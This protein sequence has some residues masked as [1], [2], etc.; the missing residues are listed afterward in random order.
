MG[1]RRHTPEQTIDKLKQ[2]EVEIANGATVAQVCKVIG[3]TDRNHCRPRWKCAGRLRVLMEQTIEGA[4]WLEEGRMKSA[5]LLGALMLLSL[6]MPTPASEPDPGTMEPMPSPSGS[7]GNTV[8]FKSTA[9]TGDLSEWVGDGGG[10]VFSY[11][12]EDWRSLKTEAVQASTE[13]KHSGKYSIRCFLPDPARGQD[14]K[15]YRERI[16][17]PVAYYSAWFWF[18]RDFKPTE[19]MNIFQWKTNGPARAEP[20]AFGLVDYCDPTFVV[21]LSYRPRIGYL[22][23][24]ALSLAGG[25]EAHTRLQGQLR[26]GRSEAG[27]AL[28][29]GAYRGVLQGGPTDG[30][31]IIWQ[32]GQEIFRVTGVN[33]RDAR[34][35]HPN[36]KPGT[37]MWGVGVYSSPGNAGPLLAYVD[38][39]L[40]TDH[41]VGRA[42][43]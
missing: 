16:L 38:D 30:Q 39:V 9:E 26:T 15:L 7:H 33:T 37:I 35:D 14:A 5:L 41:R 22:P 36:D 13:Q 2:A 12:G 3:V 10:H 19:W 1:D 27:A 8:F 43:P 40:V 34:R 32:D 20:D 23:S 6:A 21:M 31:V 11:A 42:Q 25:G 4:D 18:G 24:G 17:Q 28:P 29:M